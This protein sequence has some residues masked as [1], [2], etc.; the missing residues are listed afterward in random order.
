MPC[1]ACGEYIQYPERGYCEN[2]GAT[3]D[4]GGQPDPGDDGPDR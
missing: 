3:V 4:D 1:P 2:C